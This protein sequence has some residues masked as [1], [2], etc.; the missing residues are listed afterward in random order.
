MSTIVTALVDTRSYDLLAPPAVQTSY[1]AR[2]HWFYNNLER[3]SKPVYTFISN[4]VGFD[5]DHSFPSSIV[6]SVYEPFN[7]S[8]SGIN[9]NHASLVETWSKKP[10]IIISSPCN[11]RSSLSRKESK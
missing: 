4:L 5:L 10:S 8:D 9:P 7:A 6:V 2:L 1:L 11:S 3:P